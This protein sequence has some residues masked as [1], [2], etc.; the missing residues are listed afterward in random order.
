[1]FPQFAI[2][3]PPSH[4]NSFQFAKQVSGFPPPLSIHR[5]MYF[6]LKNTLDRRWMAGFL[7]ARTAQKGDDGSNRPKLAVAGSAEAREIP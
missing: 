5:I 2:S 1:M 7:I 3:V 6:P 4:W